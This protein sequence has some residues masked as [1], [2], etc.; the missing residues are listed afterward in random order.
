MVPSHASPDHDS[1]E[2]TLRESAAASAI[3]AAD[4]AAGLASGAIDD[5]AHAALIADRLSEEYA[6]AAQMLRELPGCTV[7]ARGS[8]WQVL[9]GLRT[10]HARGEDLGQTI[11]RALA[12]LAAELGSTDAV[13]ANRPGSWE[14]AALGDL[15]RGTVGPDDENIGD[16]RAAR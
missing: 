7:E 14:A 6:E 1:G 5:P 2:T 12:R 3:D 16:W 8:D 9:A 4:L 11:A 15:L 10:A 13:L